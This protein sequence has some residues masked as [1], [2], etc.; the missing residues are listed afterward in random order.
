MGKSCLNHSL[1]CDL[2]WFTLPLRALSG[3][4]YN[5]CWRDSQI[6][7]YTAMARALRPLGGGSEQNGDRFP[8]CKKKQN[9][10]LEKGS[11][12]SSLQK[13]RDSSVEFSF[14][15]MGPKAR[16]ATVETDSEY[17][18]P[19]QQTQSKTK[20]GGSFNLFKKNLKQFC[21]GYLN[22]KEKSIIQELEVSPNGFIQIR[23]D[24]PIRPG[25]TREGGEGEPRD[26]FVEC[27]QCSHC[28][29]EE[30]QEHKM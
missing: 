7:N 27:I 3:F 5:P 15:Y 12:Q 6:C 24:R 30:S 29:A 21:M 28:R 17:S 20:Q 8:H 2:E 14:P 4:I 22:Q 23:M 16:K 1:L 19:V 10:V 13:H 18:E 25:E 11:V 9:S 26:F